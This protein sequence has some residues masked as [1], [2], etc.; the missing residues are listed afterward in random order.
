MIRLIANAR[1]ANTTAPLALVLHAFSFIRII[2]C[3][4][5]TGLTLNQRAAT[6]SFV[7]RLRHLLMC[8]HRRGLSAT[9]TLKRCAVHNRLSISIA[10]RDQDSDLNKNL[11]YGIL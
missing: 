4:F 5:F 3:I 1:L 11:S 8:S 2:F 9:L 6:Q 10:Y 7:R